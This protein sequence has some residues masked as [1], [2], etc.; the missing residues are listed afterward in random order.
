MKILIETIPHD[1]Q[2]YPT[3]GDWFY[4]PT[5]HCD[6]CDSTIRLGSEIPPPF[7]CPTCKKPIPKQKFGR[8][9]VIRVSQLSSTA[10]EYLIA[11]HE[12]IEV[13]LCEH[14]GVTQETVDAFDMEFEKRRQERIDQ[15]ARKVIEPGVT[16][17]EEALIAI[18]EPGDD[19]NAP[20]RKQHCFATG[21]ERLLAA[22]MDVAWHSY[23][24][25]LESLP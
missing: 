2:R 21:I 5:L 23:E 3:V 14:A 12:L 13:I 4:V 22:E 7:T 11:V 19:E 9:L 18:E 10:R 20:Y 24:A 17:G 25:E 6:F 1:Q 15:A 8:M 16:S